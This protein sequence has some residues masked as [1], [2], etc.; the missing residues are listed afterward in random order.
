MT[1]RKSRPRRKPGK[2][3]PNAPGPDP[4]RLDR[5]RLLELAPDS[6][7]PELERL[8][9]IGCTLAEVAAVFGVTERTVKTRMQEAPYREAWERG[10]ARGNVSLRRRQFKA[11]MEGDRTML[12]WLGKQRLGQRDVVEHTGADGG[13]IALEVRDQLGAQLA[14]LGTRLRER[15]PQQAA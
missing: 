15:E 5:D 9:L 1:A 13:P 14:E 11:A 8:A 4:I 2:R 3:N 10:F 7:F 12:V 6:E